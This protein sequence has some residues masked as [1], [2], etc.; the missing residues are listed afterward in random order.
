VPWYA[1]VV[2][3]CVAA[4][5]FSPIDLVPDFI[6]VLGYLDDV[7][8]VPLGILAVIK[9]IPADIMAE[10][11]ASAAAMSARPVSFAA[12][13]AIAAIW[14]G[15]IALVAALV[16]ARLFRE[17]N[18]PTLRPAPSRHL[19]AKSSQIW[20]KAVRHCQK[21]RHPASG[22]V[23]TPRSRSFWIVDGAGT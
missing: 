18:R 5:A 16:H 21:R 22:G 20:P 2:A 23:G 1:K 6:P 13:S 15:S 12:A 4:Y 17:K 11:R 3:V 19:M 7:I 8:I 14:I 10:H 9:L